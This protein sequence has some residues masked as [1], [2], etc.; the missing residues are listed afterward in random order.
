MDKGRR[1]TQID[2]WG[3]IKI[4]PSPDKMKGQRRRWENPAFKRERGRVFDHRVYTK[5]GK[6]TRGENGNWVR[7]IDQRERVDLGESAT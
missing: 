6:S 3:E 2:E 4:D 7:E 1:K 5:E